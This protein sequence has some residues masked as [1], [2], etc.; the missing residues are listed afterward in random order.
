MNGAAIV[1]TII[2]GAVT[3]L[4]ALASFLWWAF[5]LGRKTGRAEERG[6]AQV[7]I[8]AQA[9]AKIITLEERIAELE[10]ELDLRSTRRRSFGIIPQQ[11]RR[12]ASRVLDGYIPTRHPR[13]E[14]QPLRDPVAP[15]V[16]SGERIYKR[17][18][19]TTEA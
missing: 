7:Q 12:P 9:V 5:T 6:A 3:A 4:A 17:R 10:T 13:G 16:A 1:A 18:Y 14:D 2:S 8:Q 19:K 15:A 11:G